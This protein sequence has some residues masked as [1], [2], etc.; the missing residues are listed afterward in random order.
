MDGQ[1]LFLENQIKMISK[2]LDSLGWE[3]MSEELSNKLE[4]GGEKLKKKQE[5]E[6]QTK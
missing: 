3:P 6:F 5:I 2:Q 4:K 1:T